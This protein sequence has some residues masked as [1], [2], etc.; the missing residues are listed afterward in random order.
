MDIRKIRK[1]IELIDETGVTEIEIREG[2]DGVRI[3]RGSVPVAPGPVQTI[4]TPPHTAP[5]ASSTVAEPSQLEEPPSGHVMKSPMVGT[6]YA[7]ASPGTKSFVEI[8]Q[9]I[10]EGTVVCI[11]E[12]MK[13]FNEI[14]ADRSGVVVACHVDN[15]QPVEYGQPIF[16]IQ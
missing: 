2:E 5:V 8:G 6:F 12:A 15:G 13:M 3:S 1:L 7:S 16:T 11:I 4:T 10:E 14:E 9:R